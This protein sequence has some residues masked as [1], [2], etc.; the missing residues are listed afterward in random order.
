MAKAILTSLFII[1]MVC[2]HKQSRAQDSSHV[3]SDRY[4][5]WCGIGSQRI[6]SGNF[7]MLEGLQSSLN[8]SIHQ[9]Q[10]FKFKAY[11][12]FNPSLFFLDSSNE[13][14]SNR[15]TK[16]QNV[17][18]SYGLGKYILKRFALVPNAGIS[19]GKA[20]WQ[21]DYLYT[22]TST[23]WFGNG[24]HYYQKEEYNYVSLMIELNCIVA[25]PTAGMGIDI[26]ANLHKNA[27]YGV[28]VSL[29]LGKISSR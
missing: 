14:E 8:F 27:D 25:G 15:L 3:Q 2:G 21:G 16:I 26:Y 11:T 1:W 28:A 7:H 19:Y 13:I 18:L 4:H 5:M 9:R 20:H 22:D 12:Y 6:L 24:R 10:F 23:S 17:S 29:L